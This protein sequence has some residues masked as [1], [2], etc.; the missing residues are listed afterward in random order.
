MVLLPREALRGLTCVRHRFAPRKGRSRSLLSDV[1]STPPRSCWP[2]RHTSSSQTFW[3]C[4]TPPSSQSQTCWSSYRWWSQ[5]SCR[6][7][8]AE[9]EAAAEHGD[10][11][12]GKLDGARF[13]KNSQGG[14][15]SIRVSAV[16]FLNFCFVVLSS[17]VITNSV[18]TNPT[19]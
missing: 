7:S 6:C 19:F 14:C 17:S 10:T 13:R 16:Y 15:R 3:S 9:R 1:A 2:C 11:E 5:W 18:T 12:A 4:Q 8:C